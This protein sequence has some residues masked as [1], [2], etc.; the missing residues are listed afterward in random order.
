MTENY[1]AE[2]APRR[3]RWPWIAVTTAALVI[4]VAIGWFA[5]PTPEP[6][7]VVETKTVTETVT[8]EVEVIEEIE[9]VPDACLDAILGLNNTLGEY[10]SS[11]V[12]VLLEYL[13]EGMGIG[14][15]FPTDTDAQGSYERVLDQMV[16]SAERPLTDASD[17]FAASDRVADYNDMLTVWEDVEE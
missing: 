17:C 11:M 12:D 13:A 8:E 16:D 4:G 2:K 10:H 5:V 3:P 9:V 15:G 14:G 6:E 7:I 1:L